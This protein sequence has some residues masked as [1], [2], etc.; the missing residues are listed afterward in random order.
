MVGPAAG[1]KFPEREPMKTTTIHSLLFV[2][3][4]C[5]PLVQAQDTSQR[6]QTIEQ[7]VLL[8]RYQDAVQSVVKSAREIS[9]PKD[10]SDA[11][12]GKR[13]QWLTL[14][15]NEMGSEAKA[16]AANQKEMAESAG[17]L[18]DLAWKMLISPDA[19]L[20]QPEVALK[21]ADIAI[22][23]G[24][25]NKVLKPRALDTKARAFFILGKRDEAIA[26]QEQAVGA[27]VMFGDKSALEATLASYKKGELPQVPVSDITSQSSEPLTGTAYISN[28]L[29]TIILPSVEFE[30]ISL[31]EAVDF[32]RKKAAELDVAEPDPSRKGVNLVIR[33]PRPTSDAA[34]IGKLRIKS[35]HLR[36]VPLDQALRYICEATRLRYKIDDFAVTLVPVGNSEDFFVRTFQVPVSFVRPNVPIQDFLK[37]RGV[38]FGEGTSA[39]LDSSGVLMVRN[40]PTELDKIEN[41]IAEETGE[42]V[43]GK[44]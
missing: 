38:G 5:T 33:M 17:T 22:E 24:G 30:D 2:S 14:V 29:R 39:I 37:E 11:A 3:T 13:V 43:P 1:L 7:K 32:L 20:R 44:E 26:T 6:V 12:L 4:L 18:N 41:L 35:L 10:S 8:K 21:L 40:T 9:N 42:K 23:L 27:A 34:P 31:E 28:K 36:N 19:K 16:A 15:N 25:G